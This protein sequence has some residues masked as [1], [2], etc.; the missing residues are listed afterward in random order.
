MRQN[1]H[2]QNPQVDTSTTL[3]I[4]TAAIGDMFGSSRYKVS[5]VGGEVNALIT[6]GATV[7]D[8]VGVFVGIGDFVGNLVGLIDGDKLGAALGD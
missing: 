3:V 6:I 5:K 2:P 7:G 8:S 1:Q 4:R